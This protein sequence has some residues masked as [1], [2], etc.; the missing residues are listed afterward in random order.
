MFV[1]IDIEGSR[2]D[3]GKRSL[4]NSIRRSGKSNDSAVMIRVA[5]NVQQTDSPCSCHF[6]NDCGNNFLAAS[7]AE[8]GDTFD[9]RIC[10][11]FGV[12]KLIRLK[13]AMPACSKYTI[14]DQGRAANSD[15]KAPD[16]MA[17]TN[18]ST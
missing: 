6:G 4:F 3:Y 11:C 14:R 18:V 17:L 7:F 1:Q 16:R 12:L 15:E 2:F 9:Q 5:A 8:I 13:R 10:H